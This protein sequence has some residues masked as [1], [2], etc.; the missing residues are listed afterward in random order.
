MLGK[1][2]YAHMR[3]TEY[4]NKCNANAVNYRTR[5]ESRGSRLKAEYIKEEGWI[6]PTPALR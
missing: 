3:E 1:D 2:A 5:Q 4:E 6:K